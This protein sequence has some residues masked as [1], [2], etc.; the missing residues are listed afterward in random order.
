[1]FGSLGAPEVIF[2]FLLALLIFGPKRLPELGRTVGKGMAEFR[3]ASNDLRRTI[4]AEMI[5]QELRDSDPRRMVRDSIRDAK[6][7]LERSL[8]DEPESADT[9]PDESS[10]AVDPAGE[11][12]SPSGSVARGGGA[13]IESATVVDQPVVDKTVVDKTGPETGN[14]GKADGRAAE[15]TDKDSSS[16][17]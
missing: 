16:T 15:R 11:A 12:A 4:N 9:S 8:R 5:Q 10:T 6:E 13:V 3:K 7:G 14:D 2:I 1:M 17:S